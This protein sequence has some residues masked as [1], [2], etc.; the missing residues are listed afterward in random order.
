MANAQSGASERDE[1]L[2]LRDELLPLDEGGESACWLDR[3]CPACGRMPDGAAP[4][5][6]SGCGEPLGRG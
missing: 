3:L 4:A 1:L 6:C 5:H 2:P